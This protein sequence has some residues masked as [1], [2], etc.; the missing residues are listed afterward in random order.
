MVFENSGGRI[1]ENLVKLIVMQ[2]ILNKCPELTF[3]TMMSK[4]VSNVKTSYGTW[5]EY[6]NNYWTQAV[7]IRTSKN[8]T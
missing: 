4:L 7:M 1:W 3:L 2:F 8:T 5:E 6:N